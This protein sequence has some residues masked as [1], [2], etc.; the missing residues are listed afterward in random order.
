[1]TA[2]ASSRASGDRQEAERSIVQGLLYLE[3]E[4]AQARL[5]ALASTIR[6]A[7]NVYQDETREET[8]A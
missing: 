2:S 3:R 5:G 7:V 8:R 4:A 6:A 1:M